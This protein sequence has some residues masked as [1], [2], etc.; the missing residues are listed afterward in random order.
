MH[1]ADRQDSQDAIQQAVQEHARVAVQEVTRQTAAV[2]QDQRILRG[3]QVQVKYGPQ[4]HVHQVQV[5]GD[6]QPP[7]PTQQVPRVFQVP[8]LPPAFPVQVP[9]CDDVYQDD[10]ADKICGFIAF[11]WSSGCYICS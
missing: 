9:E 1:D 6:Q 8:P 11:W 2:Q 7:S 4:I 3:P 5:Q 10:G